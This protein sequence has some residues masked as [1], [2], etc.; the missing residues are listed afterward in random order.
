MSQRDPGAPIEGYSEMGTK[1]ES[2]LMN[3]IRPPASPSLHGHQAQ[4]PFTRGGAT[5]VNNLLAKNHLPLL[6]KGV[7]TGYIGNSFLGVYRR[8]G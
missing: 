4:P 2:M 5:N 8:H 1:T 7:W 6:A 3:E